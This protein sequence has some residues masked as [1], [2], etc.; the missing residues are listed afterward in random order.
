M[1]QTQTQL[2]GG[3]TKNRNRR[4]KKRTVKAAS[5][6]GEAYKK[7]VRMYGGQGKETDKAAAKNNPTVVK[8]N[9]EDNPEEQKEQKGFFASVI[10][11]IKGKSDDADADA[12][13]KKAEADVKDPKSDSETD[14]A[15]SGEDKEGEEN[16]EGNDGGPFSALTKAFSDTADNVQGKVNDVETGLA[17]AKSKL[18]TAT[19]E[20]SNTLETV[21]DTVT[22]TSDVIGSKVSETVSKVATTVAS[23]SSDEPVTTPLEEAD[24]ADIVSATP[25][26]DEPVAATQAASSGSA[27]AITE[28]AGETVSSS[29]K[30]AEDSLKTLEDALKALQLAVIA[31]RTVVNATK[32]SV[33]ASTA[34][35]SSPLEALNNKSTLEE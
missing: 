5:T 12:A 1:P 27:A 11:K 32:A 13:T 21:K 34:A 26:D 7:Y 18:D 15:E 6:Y 33:V 30:A 22:N 2:V 10:D 9:A 14:A 4:N 28:L 3:K 35:S 29:V 17:N 23:P 19:G 24:A 20:I 16:K 31:A 8:D 25:S